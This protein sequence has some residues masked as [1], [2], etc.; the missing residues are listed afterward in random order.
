MFGF[1]GYTDR[2]NVNIPTG[3]LDQKLAYIRALELFN[4]PEGKAD[5]YIGLIGGLEELSRK[6]QHATIPLHFKHK[7]PDPSEFLVLV[8]TGQLLDA[9]RETEA[10]QALNEFKGDL[11]VVW[12]SSGKERCLEGFRGIQG[13]LEQWRLQDSKLCMIEIRDSES[14]PDCQQLYQLLGF[15]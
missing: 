8:T 11:M 3:S 15:S 5:F 7:L 13:V 9:S 4:Q 1:L 2:A 6:R 12:L 14:A 10:L